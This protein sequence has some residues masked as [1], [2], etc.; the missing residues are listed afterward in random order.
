MKI[1]RSRVMIVVRAAIIGLFVGMVVSAFRYL[2]SLVLT[3]WKITYLQA[4]Q[5]PWLILLIV[6]GMLLMT[7]LIGWIIKPDPMVNGSGIPQVEGQLMDALEVNAWSVLWRKFTA[8]ILTIG[9]GAFLGREGPSIQLG[10]AVG[11]LWGE[12]RGLSKQ[13]QRLLIATGAAAGLSAAFGAPVAGVLFILEEVY[14]N[15]AIATW[16]SALTGALVADLVASEA[17]GLAPVLQLPHLKLVPLQDYW[18]LV[19]FGLLLGIFAVL[20]QR[21]TLWSPKLYTPFSKIPRQYHFGIV[22][23]TLLVIGYFIPQTLGGGAE[24][25]TGTAKITPAIMILFGLLVLRFFGS[26]LAFG[27]GVPGGIFLPILTLGALAGAL[28]GQALVEMHLMEAGL[29]P[30]LMVIGMAGYFGAISKAPFTAIVLVAEMVG[31]L[32]HLV[33][34]ALVVLIAYLVVDSLGGAPI[35]ESLL[36]RMQLPAMLA[37]VTGHLEEHILVVAPVGQLGNKQIR[38]INLPSDLLITRIVR[39]GQTMLPKGDFVLQVGDEI[40][41]L[42]DSGQFGLVWAKIQDLNR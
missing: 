35:Y 19:I 24:L 23:L 15:F 34:M 31:S 22:L 6:V 7:G 32:D 5:T 28:F 42:I 3:F 4:H 12:K 25:I 36:V 8:G 16:I 9:S 1:D 20:Y 10:A 29:L 30:S 13:N 39:H 38:A 33:S 37:K 14:R 41:I 27:S 18:Y 11:Q 17:F 40:H 21:A 26:M 2:V